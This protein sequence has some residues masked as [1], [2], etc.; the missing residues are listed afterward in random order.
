MAGFAGCES[1]HVRPRLVGMRPPS[2]VHP[3]PHAKPARCATATLAKLLCLLVVNWLA[4]VIVVLPRTLGGKLVLFDR[5]FPDALVDPTR[6]R[7]PPSCAWL[8][9]MV[10]DLIP[11]P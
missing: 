8:V 1:F 2:A 10:T 9:K 6:Y 5:Y 3:D 4:Y 7:I 11:Q